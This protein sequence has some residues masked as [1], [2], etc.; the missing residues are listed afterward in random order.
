MS[1][2]T[3]VS[4][5]SPADGVQPIGQ[6]GDL[7]CARCHQ[8]IYSTYERTSM[9]QGSGPVITSGPDSNLL[10][11][12]FLHDPSGI[13]YKVFVRDKQAWFS[14]NREAGLQM[15]DVD[16]P[17]AAKPHPGPLHGEQQLDYF[18]GSGQHGRTYLYQVDGTWF[19]LPINY[20]TQRHAWGMAPAFDQAAT[21]PANL[22]TDPNCL[23]CHATNVATATPGSRSHYPAAPF[24]Q[25]G[26]GCSACHGDPS[27]HLAS[28]G[29]ASIVNPGKLDPAR[30]DSACLACHL[31]GDALVYRPG[32][33]LAQFKPGDNL[34]DTAVVFVRASRAGGG[35]RAAS[36]YEALL[37]SACKRAAGDRL[38]CTTCHDPHASPSATDRVAYYRGKC[39]SCHTGAAIATQHHPDQPDCASCHMPA[40]P[41]TDISHEQA[42]DHDI[43]R[44]PS[45][46]VATDL[47]AGET[48]LP[49]GGWR[50]SDRELGMAYAQ[51]AARGDRQAG[52]R[53]L[54]LLTQAEAAGAS[55]AAMHAQLGFLRQM[56]G[57]R[58]QARSEYLAALRQ[59]P[60]EPSP[61]ANLAV[62][63]ATTGKV[64]EALDLLNR[65]IAADP[66]QTAAGLN[67]A[68]IDCRLGQPD[69]ARAT[70][71]TLARYNPDDPSLRTLR[72]TGNYGG[73]HCDL[74]PAGEA[75]HAH[76]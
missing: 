19:E 17:A 69:K 29:H 18:I 38:T 4:A 52:E 8:A 5:A 41:T 45:P 68:F 66:T 24:T 37:R 44:Y 54:T 64:P 6:S 72:E 76:N 56:S 22:P 33:T 36:Q 74:H 71:S 70:L 48:L 61:L 31:E 26:V 49:V 32:K 47:K 3:G 16:H 58:D 21:M 10:P 50:A 46:P 39:L 53:A 51:M 2:N 20:Y 42:V 59:N 73:Q 75:V 57:D 65:L 67:L 9:A 62:I 35:G 34:S 43:E 11:G 12:E 40:R 55:D 25:G 14:Y 60:Y 15:F 23:Y 13:L 1:R 7:V 28:N 27:A 63:D 30:R